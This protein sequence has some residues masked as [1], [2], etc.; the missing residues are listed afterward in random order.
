MAVVPDRSGRRLVDI[1]GQRAAW[2][3]AFLKWCRGRMRGEAGMFLL[4]DTVLDEAVRDGPVC[5]P[6]ADWS[7][8]VTGL[9]LA[10]ERLM[11]VLFTMEDG[12][13]YGHRL[14]H[15]PRGQAPGRWAE[16]VGPVQYKALGRYIKVR[17]A[18]V[19][20]RA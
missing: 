13:W 16:A 8:A 17:L 4:P 3:A 9:V 2:I 19:P 7:A 12:G 14:G 20:E 6:A 10:H 18:E 11:T 1:A 15:W 5:V